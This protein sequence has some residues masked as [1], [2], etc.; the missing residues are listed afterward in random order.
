[1]NINNI[2][3]KKFYFK[4]DRKNGMISLIH[5][6]TK[7]IIG[8]IQYGISQNNVFVKKYDTRSLIINNNRLEEQETININWLSI[9]NINYLHQGFATQLIKFCIYINKIKYPK[10][11]FIT[12]DNMSD[13]SGKINDIYIKMG[14]IYRDKVSGINNINKMRI[15]INGPEMQL[16]MY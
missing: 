5:I 1:M 7:E 2:F 13:Y 15:N 3:K 8:Y 6:K 11:K 12:L 10:I 14:F 9:N 16:D 4:L